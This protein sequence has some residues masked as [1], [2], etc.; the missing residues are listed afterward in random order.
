[1]GGAASRLPEIAVPELIC[2]R[3]NGGAHR[4]IFVSSLSPR[5]PVFCIEP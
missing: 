4:P 1:M 2:Y 5:K 3:D